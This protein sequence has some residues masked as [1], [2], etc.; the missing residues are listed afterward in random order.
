MKEWCACLAA[1]VGMYIMKRRRQQQNSKAALAKS[2]SG[3][4]KDM[5]AGNGGSAYMGG[6]SHAQPDQDK[7][8]AMLA[9]TKADA[10]RMVSKR[11]SPLREEYAGT[12]LTLRMTFS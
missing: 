4:G 5:E 9:S 3:G 2:G 6:S 11:Q 12:C 1:L 7:V 10:A 8:A